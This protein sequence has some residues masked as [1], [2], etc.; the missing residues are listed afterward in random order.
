MSKRDPKSTKKI[1]Q[2][3]ELALMRMSIRAMR[4]QMNETLDGML[5]QISRLIPPEDSN[6]CIKYKN[7]TSKDWGK[8]LKF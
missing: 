5:D 6:R 2:T 1:N 4:D 8:F 7:Y 3:E